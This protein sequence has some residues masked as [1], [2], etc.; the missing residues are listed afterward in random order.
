MMG[1]INT[2][3]LIGA[4][5]EQEMK[6][7]MI[8]ES[9]PY[10]FNRF[11][12]N[13]NMNKLKLT[14]IDLMHELESVERSLVEQGRSYHAKSSSKP[15]GKPNGG[16]RSKKQKGIGPTIKLVAMKKPK[17]NCFKCIQKGHGKKDCP[18]NRY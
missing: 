8:L 12:M 2:T 4:K 10:C 3:K 6:I 11:K 16:K 9:L 15:K 17:G 5:L 7:D 18:Q 14:P 1:H 13:Y